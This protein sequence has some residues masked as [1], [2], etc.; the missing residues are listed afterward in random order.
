[1]YCDVPATT[2]N[3]KARSV[4]V[5]ADAIAKGHVALSLAN[6][7]L[8]LMVFRTATLSGRFAGLRR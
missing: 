6:R 1:M 3:P 7:L 2:S 8:M 5:E 4:A